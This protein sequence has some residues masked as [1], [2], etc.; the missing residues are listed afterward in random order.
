[1]V[2]APPVGREVRMARVA[3]RH[4][5]MLLAA[6]SIVS[7][8][9]DY[10]GTGDSSGRLDDPGRDVAWTDNV[11]QASEY[12][13]SL[14]L[15]S[16]SV[17]GMRLGSTIAAAA[18]NTRAVDFDSMVLWDPCESGRSFLRELTAL[19]SLRRASYRIDPDGSVE[20]SEFV[21]SARTAKELRGLNL[22]T[23]SDRGLAARVL[24]IERDGRRLSEKLRSRLDADSTT[25][26]VTTEQEA[27]IDVEPLVAAM[28]NDTMRRIVEWMAD[29]LEDA[30]EIDV[31]PERRV[32]IEL[33]ERGGT[34]IRER[35]VR[36]GPHEL[37]GIATEPMHGAHGPW[38][39]LLNVA[40][41]DHSGPSRQ[42]VELSRRWAGYGLRSLRFDLSGVGDSPWTAEVHQSAMYEPVWLDEIP[43]AARFVSPNDPA[44]AVFVGL[45][46]GAYGAL[47][48]ALLL[49]SRGV[50]A[51]N[52]LLNIE[53][54]HRLASLGDP[55]R[56]A[57]RA[58][59]PFLQRTSLKYR[60]ASLITWRLYRE[61]RPSA[62]PFDVLRRVV[63]NGSDL[64]VLDSPD[65]VH[66]FNRVSYWRLI[67]HPSLRRTKRF[68]LQIVP[69]F[70]HS[71]HSEEGRT[72]AI[73]ALDRFILGHF[74]DVSF[75]DE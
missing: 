29:P 56:K 11:G 5:A 8:R 55:R 44:N 30:K 17:V 69:G 38:I 15:D 48:A 57:V 7:L 41:E 22:V 26:D 72:R 74:A 24:V 27:L 50:C 9:F 33:Q 12:L 66:Q 75:D 37:F 61:L 53:E 3:L 32:E 71:M 40:N 21:F 19:E 35:I 18:A 14:G 39:I 52:P 25:W 73:R 62:D 4:L 36:V 2:L 13:R 10:L 70:D 46:S 6:R 1:M 23:P 49:G 64:L 63:R 45:C 60:I 59:P 42:W 54:L 31:S 16:I 68:E 28:P 67:G 20:S 34:K 65:D 58:M 47:E 43:D 51:I